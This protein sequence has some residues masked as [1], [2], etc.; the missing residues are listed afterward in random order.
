MWFSKPHKSAPWWKSVE[1]FLR[2]YVYFRVNGRYFWLYHK[3][4][5]YRV[6]LCE[7]TKETVYFDGGNWWYAARGCACGGWRRFYFRV[8]GTLCNVAPDQ[9]N[10]KQE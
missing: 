4:H 2:G 8:S 7:T 3:A 5:A 1:A 6:H 10:T 9:P